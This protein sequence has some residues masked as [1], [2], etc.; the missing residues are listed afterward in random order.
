M[1]MAEN[2]LYWADLKLLTISTR[3]L[4]SKPNNRSLETMGDDT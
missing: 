3:Y 2:I 1:D 4:H